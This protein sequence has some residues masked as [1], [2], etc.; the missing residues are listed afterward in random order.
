MDK[1]FNNYFNRLK[2]MKF[3][4][5]IDVLDEMLDMMRCE[6]FI[7]DMSEPSLKRILSF[8][9]VS[10]NRNNVKNKEVSVW[11]MKF[12]LSDVFKCVKQLNKGR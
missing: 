1:C 7:I 9:G 10:Y 6:G 2:V 5:E 4:R 8:V 12:Y 11:K 3:E